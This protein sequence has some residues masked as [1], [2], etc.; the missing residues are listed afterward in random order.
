MK[1]MQQGKIYSYFSGEVGS[2]VHV[3]FFARTQE[4]G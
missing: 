3:I 1:T 4:A 2:F